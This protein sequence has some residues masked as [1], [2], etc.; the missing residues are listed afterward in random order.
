MWRITDG[1]RVVKLTHGLAL[2]FRDMTACREDRPLRPS[3]MALLR[4]IVRDDQMRPPEWATAVCEETGE[5][6]RVNGKHTSTLFAELGP[7]GCE[8]RHVIVSRYACDTL[9]DVARLYC[10]FDSKVSA[11]SAGDI[12][13]VFAGSHPQLAGLPS[14]TVNVAVT[15]LAYRRW[16]KGYGSHPADERAELLLANV[17]FVVWL[18]DIFADPDGEGAGLLKRGPVVAA[19]A[20][21]YERAREQAGTFWAAVRDASGPNHRTA[22]RV[23]SKYLLSTSVDSGEGSRCGRRKAEPREMYVKCLHAWNAW[24]RGVTTDLKYFP[25]SKTPAA[26]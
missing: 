1:P 23:L 10:T 13:R 4:D 12:N 15:G 18:H 24:R 17:P 25:D 26:A 19:M 9:E 3:R 22:D 14:R 11:R 8:G 2:K 5:E 21:T 20:R 16:E 7:D 6:Y